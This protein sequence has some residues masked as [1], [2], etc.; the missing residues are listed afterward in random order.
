[1]TISQ[2]IALPFFII[3][4]AIL[5]VVIKTDIFKPAI[6]KKFFIGTAGVYVSGTL[7]VLVIDFIQK[8]MQS[9]SVGKL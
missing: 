6:F 3:S 5:I 9:L 8:L 1:M 4:V 7:L 2:I